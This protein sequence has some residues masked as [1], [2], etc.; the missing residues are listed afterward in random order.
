MNLSSQVIMSL[1]WLYHKLSSYHE[2]IISIHV[3]WMYCIFAVSWTSN[4]HIMN[5]SQV[6]SLSTFIVD[7]HSPN[8]HLV[9]F[10]PSAPLKQLMTL[11]SSLSLPGPTSTKPKPGVH[12]QM[13]FKNCLENWWISYRNGFACWRQTF[14]G[15]GPTRFPAGPSFFFRM[16]WLKWGVFF[17]VPLRQKTPSERRLTISPHFETTWIDHWQ[18]GP[19]RD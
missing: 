13:D 9:P 8:L 19:L 18:Y 14:F 16:H 17:V 1:S 3:S 11:P 5:L 12:Q 7:F 15:Q 4:Y 6:I 2:I 10:N